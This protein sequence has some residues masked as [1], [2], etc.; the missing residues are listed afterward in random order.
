MGWKRLTFILIPHS[1]SDIKQFNVPRVLVVAAVFFLVFAIGVMIFY[2]LGFEGKSFYMTKTKEIVQTNTI[3]E[4]QLSYLDSTLTVMSTTLD[5]I[6][7]VNE[8]IWKEYDIS[9]RDLK[10]S[11][12]GGIEVTES[13]V[14]LPMKRVLYLI[15]RMN[16]KC[17]A[18][19]YNFNTLYEFCM[20]NSDYL[21]HLPSIRPAD[22]FVMKEFGRSFDIVTNTVKNYFGVDINNVEGTPIV[23]TADGIVEEVVK[24]SD[25]YGRYVV[26][27]HGNGYKTRYTHLQTIAQ[28]N[29]KITINVGDYVKRGQQVGCMGRTGISILAVPTH[30]MYS[31]EHRG[32]MVNPADFFF[33][34]DFADETVEETAV[35]QNY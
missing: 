26:I 5:S 23:A 24:Y 21:R 3:L 28:M 8:K 35:A 1:R 19:E 9:D 34:S 32:I 27:D 13:G 14:R 25:E 15:D 22:G 20:N 31:V 17:M 4:N 30:I 29:P 16:K 7:T 11:E 12:G 2:I 18:F 10:L 6:E 33:A